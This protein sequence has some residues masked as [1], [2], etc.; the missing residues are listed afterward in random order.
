MQIFSVIAIFNKSIG[1]LLWTSGLRNRHCNT[2]SIS[3]LSRAEPARRR[4]AG[5]TSTDVKTRLVNQLTRLSWLIWITS[6]FLRNYLNWFNS[7]PSE[8][9]G[10]WVNWLWATSMIESFQWIQEMIKRS[11][12]SKIFK[13]ST[14]LKVFREKVNKILSRLIDLKHLSYSC[15]L[16]ES[17]HMN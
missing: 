10:D 9:I 6:F 2:E 13:K 11:T 5:S 4:T 1:T 16:I 8:M 17:V 12:K 3:F 15:E 7:F 14:K